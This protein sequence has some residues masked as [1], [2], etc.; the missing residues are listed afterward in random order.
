MNKKVKILDVKLNKL[1]EA[2]I[3]KIKAI[4]FDALAENQ[5][6]KTFDWDG[7][8]NSLHQIYRLI[9]AD[10]I[11]RLVQIFYNEYFDAIEINILESSHENVGRNKTYDYI[12]GCLIA[13]VCLRS[14]KKYSGNVIAIH[15][16]ETKEIY[17]GKYNM[18][19]FGDHY[20]K[21]DNFNSRLLVDGYL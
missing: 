12:A 5:A 17:I 2:V 10:T 6:F 13:F 21:S 9:K 16:K 8:V 7:R 15:Q 3:S 19:V 4:D 11:L 14:L 1:T 20:V 18:V